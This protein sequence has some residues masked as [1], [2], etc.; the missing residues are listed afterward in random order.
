MSHSELFVWPP[1]LWLH[2][3]LI[4]VYHLYQSVDAKAKL[5]LYPH[6]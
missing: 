3:L 5:A 6:T 4:F 1:D 2:K